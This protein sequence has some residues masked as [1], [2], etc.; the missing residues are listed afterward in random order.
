MEPARGPTTEYGLRVAVECLPRGINALRKLRHGFALPAVTRAR[1]A[2]YEYPIQISPHMLFI[3]EP[4][5]GWPERELD[6]HQL[7]AQRTNRIQCNSYPSSNSGG[8]GFKLF[9]L[10]SDL[11]GTIITRVTF[12][13]FSFG[14]ARRRVFG[15]ET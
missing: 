9:Y 8:T 5:L 13:F 1:I 14:A 6:T 4:E 7:A 3:L 11:G 10:S 15:H 2:Q 12:F